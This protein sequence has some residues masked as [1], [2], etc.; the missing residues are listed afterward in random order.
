MNIRIPSRNRGQSRIVR[1]FWRH[2]SLISIALTIASTCTFLLTGTSVASEGCF[3]QQYLGMSYEP[4]APANSDQNPFPGM[5]IP[6][7]AGN[8]VPLGRYEAPQISPADAQCIAELTALGAT[9]VATKNPVAVLVE[10]GVMEVTTRLA[11]ACGET[12]L[13]FVAGVNE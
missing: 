2:L 13:S 3:N 10:A 11:E 4:C 1:R 12:A 9:V 7:R 6:L 8:K 5:I